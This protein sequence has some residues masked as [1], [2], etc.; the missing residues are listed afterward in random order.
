MVTA[1]GLPLTFPDPPQK[2][3]QLRSS[4]E[5]AAFVEWSG[6]KPIQPVRAQEALDFRIKYLTCD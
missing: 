3:N 4:L 5:D 2:V 6:S 1:W